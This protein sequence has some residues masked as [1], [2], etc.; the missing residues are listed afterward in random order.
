LFTS[1]KRRL[2]RP[3]GLRLPEE[4]VPLGRSQRVGEDV[5]D[6]VLLL[7]LEVDEEVP[8]QHEV[9]AR[10]GDPVADVLG[11]EDHHLPERL[12]DAQAGIGLLEELL[13]VPVGERAQDV[14][15]VEA[16][17]GIG[18]RFLVHVGGEDA[19]A[20]LCELRAQDLGEADDQRVGLL[21]GRAARGPEAE[22]ALALAPPFHELGEDG[23]AQ[24]E[25]GVAIAEELGDVDEQVAGEL[26][27]LVRLGLQ[28]EGVFVQGRGADGGHPPADPPQQGRA[29]VAVEIDVALLAHDADHLGQGGIHGLPRFRHCRMDEQLLEQGRHPL[30]VHHVVHHGGGQGEGHGRIARGAGVLD[31]D[32]P[33]RL[34]DVHSP[35]RPV[36]ACPGE[37]HGDQALAVGAGRRLQQEIHGRPWAIEVARALHAY[38]AVVDD[39][40]A[41]RG[42]DV[43]RPGCIF[44]RSVTSTTGSSVLR[45]STVCRWLWWFGS[46]CWARI[47]GAG[48][49]RLEAAEQ[50][51]QGFDAARGRAPPPRGARAAV[52]LFRRDRAVGRSRGE[53]SRIARD[54]SWS[55]GGKASDSVKRGSTSSVTSPWPAAGPSGRK[56]LRAASRALR[57]S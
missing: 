25:E 43:H 39:D 1:S 15:G 11:P 52:R 9:D 27:D 55:T 32:G 40:V 4:Q 38:R 29:L 37:D 45:C 30:D 23:I 7:R 31:D 13:L 56:W 20:P 17:A 26:A 54:C 14:F 22:P 49:L 44:S 42:H 5:Q 35:R 33:A 24:E 10:E 21:S 46:R 34:F 18:H 28:V 48:K 6:L 36:R 53:L 3:H 47:T 50:R 19:D 16:A 12:A 8:A 2:R 41:V 57:V 51:A